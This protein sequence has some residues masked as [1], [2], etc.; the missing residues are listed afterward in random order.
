MKIPTGMSACVALVSGRQEP[1]EPVL[2]ASMSALE[3]TTPR[4]YHT[5]R[6]GECQFILGEAPDMADALT[7]C[8]PVTIPEDGKRIP[9]YC[10]AHRA[11]VLSK[12]QT[13]M[14]KPATA[15]ELIRSLRKYL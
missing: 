6:S 12:S 15:N 10:D 9:A 1:K 2:P 8:A 5:H 4:P 14:K 7:C 13:Y 3:G 11:I